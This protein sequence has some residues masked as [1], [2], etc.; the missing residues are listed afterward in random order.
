MENNYLK[1]IGEIKNL[2]TE[3]SKFLVFTTGLSGFFSGIF[4]IVGMMVIYWRTDGQIQNIQTLVSDH[5]SLI[6]IVLSIVFLL[7][8]IATLLFTKRNAASKGNTAWNPI[9]KKMVFN[10]YAVLVLGG[11]YLFILFFRQQYE[12]IVE[13]MLIFYGLALING[14]KYT[15]SEVR[16][17]GYVEIALGLICAFLSGYDF[18]FWVLGFGV[19]NLGY[20]CIMYFGFGK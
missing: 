2:M 18:W 4:A 10:F 20:G 3:S 16:V 9:A 13:L 7:S 15:F 1:D 11:A 19:V 17:L 5:T 12:P 14:S 6:I 8:L